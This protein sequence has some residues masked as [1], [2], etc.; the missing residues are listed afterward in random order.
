VRKG[1]PYTDNFPGMSRLHEGWLLEYDL[2]RQTVLQGAGRKGKVEG[3]TK[4]HLDTI[5][6]LGQARRV[7]DGRPS[8]EQGGASFVLI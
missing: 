6:P 8:E 2:A 3:K 4:V 5:L 1:R 7:R